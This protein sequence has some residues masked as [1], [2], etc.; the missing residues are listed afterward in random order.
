MAQ[1]RAL[2]ASDGIPGRPWFRHLIYAPLPSYEAETL[3]GLREALE[4][5][6][7]ERAREQAARLG[8]AIERARDAA[9]RDASGLK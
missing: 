9:R 2:L 3:P 7:L 6:D 8:A 1:E 4:A 5:R